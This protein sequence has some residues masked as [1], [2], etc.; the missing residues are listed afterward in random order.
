MPIYEYRC[1]SCGSEFELLVLSGGDEDARCPECGSRDLAKL[2]SSFRC[3]G[4]SGDG[5][6]RGSPSSCATCSATSCKGCGG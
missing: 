5:G 4:A 3:V 1:E 2:V 6:S